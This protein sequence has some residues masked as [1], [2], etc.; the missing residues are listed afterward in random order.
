M[1]IFGIGIDIVDLRKRVNK[2]YLKYGDKFAEK[3]LNEKELVK[4][5]QSRNKTSFLGK[6]FAVKGSRKSFGNRYFKW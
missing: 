6:R 3:I 2:I 1:D 4:F 5:N